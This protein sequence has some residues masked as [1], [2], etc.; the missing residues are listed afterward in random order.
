LR[1]DEKKM[2][3]RKKSY[4][5]IHHHSFYTISNTMRGNDGNKRS[6]ERR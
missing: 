6:Q 4:N 3:H 5:L 1:K 2:F